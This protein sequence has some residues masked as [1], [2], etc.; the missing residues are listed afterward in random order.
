MKRLCVICCALITALSACTSQNANVAEPVREASREFVFT[1]T[2]INNTFFD[3]EILDASR[4]VPALDKKDISLPKQLNELTEGYAINYRVK[5]AE[6]VWRT[7][8]GDTAIVIKPDQKS[9]VI[10]NPA[11]TENESFIVL[12]N[13]SGQTVRLKRSG[14]SAYRNNLDR[15]GRGPGSR[16]ELAPGS[17]NVYLSVTGTNSFS[18][19]TDQGKNAALPAGSFSPGWIYGFTFDGSRVLLTDARPLHNAGET[20]W[21]RAIEGN[22]PPVFTEDENRN[23]FLIASTDAGEQFFA[24]DAAGKELQKKFSARNSGAPVSITGLCKMPGGSLLVTG[25]EGIDGDFTPLLQKRTHD[26][27]LVW[28]SSSFK[29]KDRNYISLLAAARKDEATWAAA[30]G[31][32]AGGALDRDRPYIR[33]IKD[34]GG[35]SELSWELGPSDIKKDAWEIIRSIAYNSGSGTYIITGSNYEAPEFTGNQEQ[36]SFVAFINMEGKLQPRDF[37]LPGCAINQVVCDTEGAFY[38]CLQEQ[39][40]GKAYAAVFKYSAEGK[41]VTQ[42]QQSRQLK[43]HAYYQCALVDEEFGQIVL[44]GVLNARNEYG[45]S[46]KPFIQGLDK[47]TG[48]EIW[49]EELDSVSEGLNLVTGLQKAENYGFLLTLCAVRENSYAGP[50][51]IARLNARAKTVNHKAY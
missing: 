39:R 43:Q 29:A 24:L 5:L 41:R 21:H 47:K 30:G 33:E 20:T 34:R 48:E 28:E 27:V 26:N 11:F 9:A 22:Y 19:E 40:D 31:A 14:S 35:M 16:P 25:Y 23:I 36:S 17:T 15:D 7:I 50:Y 49:F 45:E 38:L 44:G 46:G 3:I 10:E 51:I 18:L 4:S 13:D 8:P 42:W 37:S 2:I 6:G 32:S 1:V 12:R